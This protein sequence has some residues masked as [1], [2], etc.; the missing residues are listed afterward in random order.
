MR[1]EDV[2]KNCDS[3]NYELVS[4]GGSTCQSELKSVR[5]AN[6]PDG[7]ATFCL[8]KVEIERRFVRNFDQFVINKIRGTVGEAQIKV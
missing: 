7:G 1:T 3:R 4:R 2:I 6:P 5:T 8:C